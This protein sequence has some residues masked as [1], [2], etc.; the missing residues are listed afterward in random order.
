MR[1][2]KENRDR[3]VNGWDVIVMIALLI[4]LL[5]AGFYN[6][7]ISENPITFDPKTRVLQKEIQKLQ[8]EVQDLK[9]K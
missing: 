9:G 3:E 6:L 7:C 4:V 8:K 1:N 5:A 2:D